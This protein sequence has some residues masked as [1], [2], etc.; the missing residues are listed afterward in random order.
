M[1]ISAPI[2]GAGRP[3]ACLTMIWIGTALKFD[4]AL[5]LHKDALIDTAASI[6]TEL[7]RLAAE[8]SAE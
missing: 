6:S 2:L 5:R 1:S 3:T 7:A 4:D 8:N